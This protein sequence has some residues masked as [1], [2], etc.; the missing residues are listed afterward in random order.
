KTAAKHTRKL[1]MA[2]LIPSLQRASNTF[3]S[4]THMEFSQIPCFEEPAS[5]IECLYGFSIFGTLS[6]LP[7]PAVAAVARLTPFGSRDNLKPGTV[8]LADVR[9]QRPA[10]APRHCCHA[11]RVPTFAG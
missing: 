9:A 8:G 5:R 7:T 1:F 2:W 4:A 3:P 11:R 6:C 10:R